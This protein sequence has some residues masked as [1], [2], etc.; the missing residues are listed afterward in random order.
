[1]NKELWR[2]VNNRKEE[3]NN[4]KGKSITVKDTKMAKLITVK[5]KLEANVP[6]KSITV[7]AMEK[8]LY[9]Y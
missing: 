7:K 2:E 5:W 1:M 9:D 4:S 8:G 6:P 3:V